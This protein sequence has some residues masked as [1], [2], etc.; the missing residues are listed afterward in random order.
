MIFFRKYLEQTI[1]TRF[2]D[3]MCL[4]KLCTIDLDGLVEFKEL[5]H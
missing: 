3:R 2:M 1:V 4:I 5:I